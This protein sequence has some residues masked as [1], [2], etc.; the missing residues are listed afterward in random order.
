MV[1]LKRVL[2][3]LLTLVAVVGL[4]GCTSKAADPKVVEGEWFLESFGGKSDLEPA[5]PNVM[6]EMTLEAGTA[7]GNGGVNSFSGPYKVSGENGLTFGE[8]N[9]TLIAGSPEAD[10]QEARFLEALQKTRHFEISEGKL[11]L[12]SN[13]NDTLAVL[14]RQ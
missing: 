9:R 12:S 6:T 1:D 3:V 7:E 13:N 8:M 2:C 14:A 11:I 10:A 5:D 4:I